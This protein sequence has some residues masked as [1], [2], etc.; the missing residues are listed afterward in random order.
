MKK[1]LISPLGTGQLDKNN[2]N[3]RT[4]RTA[5]YRIEDKEYE[6]SFIAQALKQHLSLDG[7]VF[8]G[9]VKSM[10]EEV[11]RVFSGENLDENYWVTLGDTVS[12]ANHETLLEKLNLNPLEETLGDKYKCILIKY[13]LNEEELQ[14]NLE[15]TLKEI[16]E[17][18]KKI[19]EEIEIYLD[20]TH[21]FRSLALYVFLI[22]MLIKNLSFG[23]KMEIKGIYYGM[24]DIVNELGFAKIVD[25]SYFSKTLDF[26]QASYEFDNYGNGFLLA[27]LLKDTQKEMATKIEKFSKAMSMNYSAHVIDSMREIQN[28]NIQRPYSFFRPNQLL[29]TSQ[30]INNLSKRYLQELELAEWHYKN[31]NYSNAYILLAE[32]I[33]TYQCI[34]EDRNPSEVEDRN[35]AKESLRNLNNELGRISWEISQIRNNIAHN[36]PRGNL[37]QDFQAL[38]NYITEVKKLLKKDRV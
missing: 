15:H 14:Y 27:E 2:Q 23:K 6:T 7:I 29:E 12:Q 37:E 5:R 31:K 28:L 17:Y 19:K 33:V 25:L 38:G 1:I 3:T 8:I 10:W 9:T 11:Y 36:I 20:I 16:R 30:K 32:S 24:L 4:Y 18:F 13:G 21:S 35:A 26:I 34:Q 22:M